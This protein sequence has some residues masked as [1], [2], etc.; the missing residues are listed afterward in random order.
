MKK[1]KNQ[2]VVALLTAGGIGSRTN[3]DIP[4]QFLHIDNKPLLIY[5]LEAFEK[6]PSV[7]EIIVVCLEG[8]H[9]ILKAYAKQFN[10]TKMKYVVTGGASGQESIYNGIVELKKYIN[11]DDIVMVHD[12]NRA[13]ISQEIISDCLS[14]YHKNGSAVVA[15][16]CVEAVFKSDDGLISN[17][18]IPRSELYRT[19]TPH[20]YSLKKLLWAH[21]EAKKRNITNSVATCTL[22]QELGETIYLC[23][24]SEKNLKVTTLDD[25]EIFKS[26]LHTSQD[27]WLK[28]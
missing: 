9:E 10:I 3:Q 2:K 22:M 26:L 6:H 24:G 23:K 11:E 15:I 13:L 25:I 8:W 20:V 21:D 16:P 17:T 12:G 7:D 19:Q 27:S 5:T 4:K 18:Q 28:K 14:C 1:N